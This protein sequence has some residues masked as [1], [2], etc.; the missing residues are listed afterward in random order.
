VEC[1]CRYLVADF[2]FQFSLILILGIPTWAHARSGKAYY[3]I[4][5]SYDHIFYG[6]L[7]LSYIVDKRLRKVA[8]KPTVLHTGRKALQ[9][10]F[11]LTHFMDTC[12]CCHRQDVRNDSRLHLEFS[13]TASA[14]LFSSERVKNVLN[15]LL[16]ITWMHVSTHSIPQEQLMPSLLAA[17]QVT[18]L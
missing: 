12:I 6:A 9:K 2:E 5:L 7:F 1:S 18:N 8:L 11:R 16:S 10:S 17:S 15:S 3:S 14:S 13:L 4:W